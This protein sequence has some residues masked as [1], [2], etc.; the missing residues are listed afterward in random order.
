MAG[1]A[2]VGI[3]AFVAFHESGDSRDLSRSAQ[4][5]ARAEEVVTPRLISVARLDRWQGQ[6]IA[7]NVDASLAANRFVA[8]GPSDQPQYS[9]ADYQPAD[10]TAP[11]VSAPHNVA[12]TSA[13]T[14]MVPPPLAPASESAEA[15]P[16]IDY[17]VARLTD[18][19]SRFIV[20]E[21]TGRI[22]GVDGTAG[23]M[24]EARQQQ[25]QLAT[26]ARR[27]REVRA[28]LP[29]DA[30]PAAGLPPAKPDLYPVCAP[31]DARG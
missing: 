29:V 20:D 5:A 30:D 24:E 17:H 28:A 2:G 7:M 15:A 14:T 11:A 13:V 8:A 18:P 23:A 9:Y 25:Q 6:S 4:G 12:R 31:C 21:N 22:V 10:S 1:L 16:V 3:A 27:E 26:A 19:G